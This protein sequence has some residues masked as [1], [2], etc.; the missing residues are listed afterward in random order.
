MPRHAAPAHLP[1]RVMA[2]SR[3]KQNNRAIVKREKT[4]LASKVVQ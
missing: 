2:L 1:L 4:G 3:G